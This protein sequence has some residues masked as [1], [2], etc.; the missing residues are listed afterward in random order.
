MKGVGVKR[1][2]VLTVAAFAFG[3]FAENPYLCF[4]EKPAEF[5]RLIPQAGVTHLHTE[6][7]A[8]NAIWDMAVSP[9]GRVFFA[10][11]G[12][13]YTSVYARMYE[14]D[15][16]KKRLVR[17]F[18]LEKRL[19]IDDVGLRTSK[20][21]TSMTFLGGGKMLLTTHTTSPS[22]RHPMWMP[23][24]Y[25]NHPFESFK[26]S[27]LLIF[28]YNTGETRGLGKFTSRDTVYGA[29]YDPKNG[30]Y[31]GIT[32]LTGRGWVY[33]LH[34]GEKRCLG[35]ITDS[36]SSRCFLCSDG[37][38]Y[39]SS[40]TGAMFR[41]NT[42]KRDIEFLG[43]SAS[44]LLRQACEVDGTLYFFTGTCGVPGRGLDFY[45]YRLKT[46]KLE[47]IGHPCPKPDTE[48]TSDFPQYQAYGMA[49]D[50]KGR[51]WY[52]CH[53][54]TPEIR[55]SGAKLYMWDFLHGKAPVD[56]GFLGTPKRTVSLVAE[57]KMLKGD[58]L[59][60]TDGN[61]TSDADTPCGILAIELDKFVPALENPAYP[62]I[63]SH[64]YVNYLPYPESNWKYYPKDDFEECYARYAKYHRD[65]VLKF[66]RFTIDNAFRIS[67]AGASG[68][69]VWERIGREN[70]AVRHIEWTGNSTLSFWC[71]KKSHKVDCELDSNG[72]ARIVRISESAMKDV[73]P[74]KADVGAVRL[75]AMPG[76]R[77]IAEAEA[78]VKLPDGRIF[79][80]TKD[81]MLAVINCDGSVLSLGGL[82]TGGGVHSLDVAPNGTVWG[83]S[84]HDQGI[85]MVFNWTDKGGVNVLGLTP[86]VKAE[87]GRN[88]HIY[89]PLV[90]AVSP[91]GRHVAVGGADEL[92]GAVVFPA[93][94]E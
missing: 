92:A 14:Y 63:N 57:M 2:L 8:H 28:D 49:F 43:V 46:G 76:R 5:F 13:S 12:E 71:G 4:R 80:G 79:V 94:G 7:P 88:V 69:S 23:Y 62:R 61:H 48:L 56:C 83:V 17:H 53:A 54:I 67:P 87:N 29:T 51:M 47:H 73:N 65:T 86:D 30:D 21:H 75:P 66:R 40:Y 55:F 19:S 68:V 37:H 58:V 90:I 1:L 74:I 84:G 27:D 31:L 35:Q 39:G 15:Y 72:K 78:S 60:V 81:G 25:F 89:T 20:F 64:D 70:A 52:G 32:C 45:A 6:D 3:A 91:D 38:I 59:V 77:Y 42:D 85:G 10:S 11:C 82:Q 93:E 16:A 34:T 50:S 22:P 9:E 33:N 41:Y 24:E 44:G 18:D 26:G 36:R